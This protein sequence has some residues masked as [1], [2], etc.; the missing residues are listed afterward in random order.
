[1]SVCYQIETITID[2]SFRGTPST[3]NLAD[4]CLDTLIQVSIGNVLDVE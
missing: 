3:Q 1:M 2:K 4:S